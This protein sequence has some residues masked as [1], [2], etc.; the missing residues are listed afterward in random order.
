VNELY[1]ELMT[2]FSEYRVPP[3]FFGPLQVVNYDG[4]AGTYED[5]ADDAEFNINLNGKDL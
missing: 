1:N 5:N 2:T 4:L 3:S